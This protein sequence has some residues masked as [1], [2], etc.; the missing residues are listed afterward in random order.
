MVF[1]FGTC[2]GTVRRSYHRHVWGCIELRNAWEM[3]QTN[4][5]VAAHRVVVSN[6]CIMKP[7]FWSLSGSRIEM[8]GS[9]IVSVRVF[10]VKNKQRLMY[11]I[12][13]SDQAGATGARSF[14]MWCLGLVVGARAYLALYRYHV[15]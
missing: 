7:F 8:E 11:F 3:V 9:V 1:F 10:I 4:V 5:G 12:V 13:K 2:H 15:W 14:L 6:S